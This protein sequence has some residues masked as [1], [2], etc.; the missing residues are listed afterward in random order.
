MKLF[1]M[2]A[3]LL[4]ALSLSQSVP[5][6][7]ITQGQ[8]WS[9]AQW[10]AAWQSKTDYPAPCSAMPSFTGAFT[11]SGCVL[12]GVLANGYGGTGT[13]TGVPAATS[14]TALATAGAL[15]GTES[16]ICVQSGATD[17]CTAAQINGSL[18]LTALETA[19][20]IT[21]SQLNMSWPPYDIRRYG[22]DLTGVA[23]ST[24]AMTLAHSTGQTI[25]YPCGS[26]KFSTLSMT[27]GG[28]V[29]A[30]RECVRFLPTDTGSG[31]T[32]LVTP[33][34][35]SPGPGTGVDL[36]HFSITYSSTTQKTSGYA[37]SV[38]P[39]SGVAEG[40][41]IN[42][43]YCQ[44]APTCVYM[45]ETAFSTITSSYFW[46]YTIGGVQFYNFTQQGNGDSSVSSSIFTGYNSTAIGILQQGSSGLKIHNN[47]FLSGLYG[48]QASV[49][50]G[51]T[52]SILIIDGN[53]FES[54][55]NAIYLSAAGATGTISDVVISNNEI[56]TTSNACITD[57][58]V[59]VENGL[60]ITGNTCDPNSGTNGI[61]LLNPNQALIS[62][63]SLIGGGT[64]T[65]LWVAGSGYVVIGPNEIQGFSTTLTNTGS[66]AT[67][68]FIPGSPTVYSGFGTSP[69]IYG[70][71][72]NSPQAFIL[73]VGTGGTAST[74]VIAL[75]AAAPIGWNCSCTDYSHFSTTAFMC[76]V[77]PST[78]TTVT[79]TN[80][81]TAAT[82]A[83]W[84]SGD[85]LNVS[86][87]AE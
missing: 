65:G 9:A 33:S 73:N 41:Y 57:D 87:F 43:F 6:G 78:T 19:A 45:G 66:R 55:T 32:I 76:R 21:A 27:G 80:Y 13:T 20:G 36:E 68:T 35:G 1:A 42:D 16:L 60:T 79:V 50:N 85:F 69:Y 34:G 71:S 26:Y 67:Q 48:Y 22:A 39:A 74:G 75:P 38:T 84:P 29:G 10:N 7:T 77:T 81:N 12:S 86:C 72:A 30:S 64:S 70:G 28:I 3:L 17:K 46:S 58:G 25:F 56:D 59:I 37:V 2:L 14:I 83:A 62:A 44:Y 5:N 23:D 31:A 49:F 15:T 61:K 53:S 11:S 8:V 40:V 82:A 52:L 4:P 18:G 51:G 63:N 47:K 24:A 54:L